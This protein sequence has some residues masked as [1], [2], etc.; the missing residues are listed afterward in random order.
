M[1]KLVRDR[2][3]HIMREAGVPAIIR[4]IDQHDRLRWLYE[5][6]VE[7][8]GELQAASSLD[9]C[10]DVLEVL[11]S[12]AALLGHTLDE[13]IK[14]ADVKRDARGAFDDGCILTVKE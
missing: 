4:Y 1:E 10:A 13:V 11:R 3:P 5:K 9:E 7:E 2:I 8:V 6:L 14:A 12:I